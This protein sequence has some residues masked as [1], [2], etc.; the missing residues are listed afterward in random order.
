MIIDYDYSLFQETN[1]KL[2]ILLGFQTATNTN[3]HN[4]KVPNPKNIKL[5]I[6]FLGPNNP[7]SLK[8]ILF[9]PLNFFTFHTIL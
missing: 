3:V 1:S 6:S 5:K 2:P 9:L 8:Q 7:T 4:D